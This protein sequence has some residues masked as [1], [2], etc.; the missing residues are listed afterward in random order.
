M[1]RELTRAERT[2]IRNLVVAICANYDSNY[3]C[4]PLDCS[5]YMLGKWW[6][7]SYCRYFQNAVL[8][9]DPVLSAAL[10]DGETVE[11]R[12]CSTCGKEF[13]PSGKQAYCSTACSDRARKKRQRE[14]MR[15]KRG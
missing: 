3:G 9:N 8:P 15:K 11:K 13:V 1:E 4:L 12:V 7:G 6:I 10:L 2:A 14:Y 5:C